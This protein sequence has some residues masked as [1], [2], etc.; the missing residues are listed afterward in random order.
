MKKSAIVN[1]VLGQKE[2]RWRLMEWMQPENFKD[3]EQD[4]LQKLKNSLRKNNFIDPFFGT[5]TT[6][7]AAHLLDRKGFGIELDPLYVD[8]ILIRFN[9]L[10]PHSSFE[11]VNRKFDF[12][13]LFNG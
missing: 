6:I 9:K 10:Y 13:K 12:K 5:G 2:I 11:C 7:I 4:R 3:V 1:K 8:L